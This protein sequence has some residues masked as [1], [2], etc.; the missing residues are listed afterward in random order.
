[1]LDPL[2]RRWIGPPLDRDGL[3]RVLRRM[4]TSSAVGADGSEDEA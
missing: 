4:A 1:M 3:D 2:L